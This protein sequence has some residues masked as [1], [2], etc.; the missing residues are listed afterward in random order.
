MFVASL[1]ILLAWAEI[2]VCNLVLICILARSRKYACLH[3]T[4]F[5]NSDGFKARLTTQL[6]SSTRVLFPLTYFSLITLITKTEP[7][8]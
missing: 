3:L 8:T 6:D 5:K 1:L 2:S 7:S 4:E